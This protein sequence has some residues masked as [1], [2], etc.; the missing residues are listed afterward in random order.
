M[1]GIMTNIPFDFLPHFFSFPK[2]S[3]ICYTINEL[4]RTSQFNNFDSL[5]VIVTGA[6]N[7][8]GLRL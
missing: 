1:L 7:W 4:F 5:P 8:L 3:M 6:D 2:T